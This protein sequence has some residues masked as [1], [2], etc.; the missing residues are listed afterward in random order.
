MNQTKRK[1]G[2]QNQQDAMLTRKQILES[3]Y[4]LFSYKGVEGTSL[5]EIGHHT[6]I[7]HATITHHFGNKNQVCHAVISYYAERYCREICTL[8][9]EA[10]HHQ[11]QIDIFNLLATQLVDITLEY[12]GLFRLLGALK[13]DDFSQYAAIIADIESAHGDLMPL[14]QQAKHSPNHSI[15]FSFNSFM[16][17]LI[18][19]ASVPNILENAY[20]SDK[21]TQTTSYK[22]DI[23]GALLL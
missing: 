20:Y 12:S 2:R 3:A 13:H 19:A 15:R 18:G 23:L 6:G 1:V 21:D 17:L 5:R 14:F 9:Q 22:S 16:L 11:S 10:N 7:A 8:A 4:E